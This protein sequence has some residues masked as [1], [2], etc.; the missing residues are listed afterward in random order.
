MTDQ[1]RLKI[2]QQPALRCR[3]APG[4]AGTV[5]G[6]SPIVATPG[7]GIYTVSI[8]LAA[9]I[10][11]LAPT[12]PP[13]DA[14]LT[15]IGNLTGTGILTRTAS[16]TW[17]QRT[18]AAPAA[19]ITIANPAGIAGDPTFALANDLAALEGIGS[20]NVI[21]YRSAADTW[22][23]VT[24]GSGLSFAAGTL[25]VSGV[26]MAGGRLTLQTVT[27]VMT[28]TQSAKTTV[29][30]TPYLHQFVPIYDGTNMT[31]TDIGGELSQATTDATKS[32]AAVAASKNYDVFVWS[33]GGTF[34][35]TRG[36]VWTSD[37]A[38]GTGAGTSELVM[39]KGVL[40]NANA[41]TNGPSTQRGTYV[42]TIRSNGSSQI[43]WILGASASGGTAAVLN[44]WNAYNRVDVGTAVT[45][46]GTGY[47]LTSATVRQA[48]ASAGNQASFVVGLNEDVL[49]WSTFT[50]G[51]YAAV[52]GANTLSGPGFDTTSAYSTIA[53]VSQNAAAAANN[54]SIPLSGI[55]S[56]GLG[57]H[58]ISRNESGDGANA[59]SFDS[60]AID[61]LHIS[62]RM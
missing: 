62:M 48:R 29:Y 18:L 6:T 11:A 12:Y 37:T 20:T 47:T 60:A 30:Y 41:I 27:P 2:D 58:F 25:V 15:A 5:A 22:A 17:A 53:A 4:F 7:G 56:P 40:L 31:M 14:D 38:R 26:A 49:R 16:N 45:D 59:N 33:D 34:R 9:L 61:A 54:W 51:T 28:T 46:S 43:D 24:I 42:G 3:V 10:A 23:T 13:L 52:T 50:R 19:G 57:T 36:P 8:D 39:V 44:V 55:W 1:I 32:P 21:P 35:A